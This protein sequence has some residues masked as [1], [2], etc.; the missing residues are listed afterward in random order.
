MPYLNNNNKPSFLGKGNSSMPKLNQSSPKNNLASK[1]S[2]FTESKVFQKPKS[3][4]L[5]NK[6][7]SSA[8]KFDR[9]RINLERSLDKDT[10]ARRDLAKK[11]GFPVWSTKMNE[12]V[13][14]IKKR[15]PEIFG[16]NIDEQES[17]SWFKPEKEY[18]E[19]K[20]EWEKAAPGGIDLGESKELK[21]GDVKRK[22]LE[23]WFKPHQLP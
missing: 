12:A 2:P 8:E 5:Q 1:G 23:E 4:A 21:R 7:F 18:W 16:V 14:D 15:V 13:K 20:H 10:K 9:S 17:R 22:F 6:T 19:K 11:L 3:P